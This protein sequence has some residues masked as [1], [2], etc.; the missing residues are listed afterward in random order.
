MVIA[1]IERAL[2][3]QR[4]TNRI[5]FT[6]NGLQLTDLPVK[7]N[8]Y[9]CVHFTKMLLAKIVQN[10]EDHCR[11]GCGGIEI[12]VLDGSVDAGICFLLHGFIYGK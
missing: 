6:Q 10:G 9:P 5:A 3:R 7:G 8:A 2:L 1:Q 12:L 4:K 11:G